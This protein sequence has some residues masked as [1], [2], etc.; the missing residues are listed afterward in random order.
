MGKNTSLIVFLPLL[1]ILS[2]KNPGKHPE[3]KLTEREIKAY[4]IRGDSIVKLTFDTLRTA[5]IK[6]MGEK[7]AALSIEYCNINAYPITSLHAKEGITIRR[8]AERYRNPGNTPDS[9]EKIVLTNYLSTIDKKQPLESS[10]IESGNKVHYFKPIIL[11]A[12]C[13]NC[14]GDKNI[15]IQPDVWESIQQKYPGDLAY[16]FKEGDLRG[17]WHII[18]PKNGTE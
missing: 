6:S 3:S 2:C 4:S 5:L 7:G 17:A 8:T 13:L 16:G 1:T 10:I 12:M 18:F 9:I 14:H 15:E 11:Q